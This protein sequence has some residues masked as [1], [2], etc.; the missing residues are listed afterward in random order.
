MASIVIG[1][2]FYP[3]D[4]D[5][6]RRQE[7]ARA[8]LRALPDAMPVNLQFTDE[9]FAP[10]GFLTLPV[11]RLDSRTVTGAPGRRKP[12]VSEMLDALADAARKN[13]CRYFAYLNADIEAT[14]AALEYIRSRGRD[15][16]AFCRVDVDADTRG[17]LGIQPYGIDMVAFEVGWWTRARRRFRPYIAGE[18]CWDNVYAALICSLGHGDIVSHQ[19][20]IFHERHPTAW[21]AHDDPFAQYNGYLAA[22]DAPYFSRWVDYVH[23]VKDAKESEIEHDRTIA[24]IFGARTTPLERITHA[25]RQVRARWRYSRLRRRGARG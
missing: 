19:P 12:I 8:A 10:D 17:S 4:G 9:T 22:L 16:Y 1:S 11:L 14:P 5:G 13:G 3:A 7:R 20:L 21:Q 18:A 2:A 23:A 15:G 24:R 6:G 25:G